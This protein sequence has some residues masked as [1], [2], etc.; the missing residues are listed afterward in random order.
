MVNQDNLLREIRVNQDNHSVLLRQIVN[1]QERM[2]LELLQ[3]RQEIGRLQG[4]QGAQPDNG[5]GHHDH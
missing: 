5:D 1:V 2:H 4:P 3:L